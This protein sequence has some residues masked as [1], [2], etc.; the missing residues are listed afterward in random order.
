MDYSSHYVLL[1]IELLMKGNGFSLQ[2]GSIFKACLL[3]T[4]EYKDLQGTPRIIK[5]L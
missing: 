2:H 1:V 5:E 3:D 4:S